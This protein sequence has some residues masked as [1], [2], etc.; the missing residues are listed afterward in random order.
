MSISR[1][2]RHGVTRSVH[3]VPVWQAAQRTARTAGSMVFGGPLLGDPDRQPG[4]AAGS[5]MGDAAREAIASPTTRS[6][7]R[8]RDIRPVRAARRAPE[9][10]HALWDVH[11]QVLGRRLWQAFAARRRRRRSAGAV[12][13]VGRGPR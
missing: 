3:S 4:S 8:F 2:G 12:P 1:N 11:R 10:A 13:C 7:R 5:P 6:P 9:C